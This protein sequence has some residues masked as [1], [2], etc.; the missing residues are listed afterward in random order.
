MLGLT[1]TCMGLVPSQD[2]PKHTRM[3]GLNSSDK[4]FG[5]LL[6]IW[7]QL[8]FRHI[9]QLIQRFCLQVAE[10][11]LIISCFKHPALVRPPGL[12]GNWC[13]YNFCSRLVKPGCKELWLPCLL[14]K[15]SYTHVPYID[16]Q[17]RINSSSG[18]VNA[19]KRLRLQPLSPA[20][21]DF[22]D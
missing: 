16:E 21:A 1:S 8:K 15:C 19:C 14:I 3:Q 13:L 20:H 5:A 10:C 4:I 6:L 17:T 2:K 22:L 12:P 18:Y 11:F 9:R 7:C